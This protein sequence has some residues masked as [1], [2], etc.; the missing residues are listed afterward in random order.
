MIIDI[1]KDAVLQN[2]G[3]LKQAP[4][5][6]QKRN[7]M[8]C[9][10]QGHGADTRTRF[11][12]QFNPQS[13]A[14]NCFNCG[15]SAGYTEGKELS[16][17]FKFFL[18]QL[19]IDEK[20]IEQ[21]EFEI[22]KERNKLK[23]IREGD[24]EKEDQETRIR[25]L[26]NK[27][28]P[29]E[30]PKDSLRIQEWLEAGLD[31]PNFLSVVNYAIKRKILNLDEFYWTPNTEYNLHQR[32]IIPYYYKNKIVGFTARLCYDTPNKAIPKYFQ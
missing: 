27:W 4:K 28:Q 26:F 22:F 31:D 15:F 5:N 13:I 2:I 14:L 12:I 30:L 18:K 16:K 21:I 1:L 6:W 3:I 29:I 11:G 23:S 32:L 9:H 25:K 19:H 24:V 17:S 10:T 7:C 8:L 20:F